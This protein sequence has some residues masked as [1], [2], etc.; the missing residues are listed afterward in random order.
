[1]L[2]AFVFDL[3]L[4]E[5]LFVFG[6]Y[7]FHWFQKDS[8]WFCDQDAC[9]LILSFSHWLVCVFVG[10]R[11]EK[12]NFVS[13]SLLFLSSRLINKWND[14][15]SSFYLFKTKKYCNNKKCLN[16]VRAST[17]KDWDARTL[18]K[19]QLWQS[20]C[21]NLL[22]NCWLVSSVNAALV[23][24]R[25]CLSLCVSRLFFFNRLDKQQ[26]HESFSLKIYTSWEQNEMKRHSHK[27]NF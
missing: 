19:Q 26:Q 14:T 24:C 17:T 10:W 20:N 4:F 8:V 23:V 18:K 27:S 6:Y 3:H 12:T 5:W 21:E 2:L 25:Q 13:L 1:M 9:L 22:A 11:S 7:F 16:F 15:F